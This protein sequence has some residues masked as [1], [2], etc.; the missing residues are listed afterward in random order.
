MSSPD[1]LP[2]VQSLVGSGEGATPQGLRFSLIHV[3]RPG[4]LKAWEYH[5]VEM[6]ET[7]LLFKLLTTHPQIEPAKHGYIFAKPKGYFLP[8][9]RSLEL[10]DIEGV[11][12]LV[13]DVHNTDRLGWDVAYPYSPD[14]LRELLGFSGVM[15]S[16]NTTGPVCDRMRIILPLDRLHTL[17]EFHR[18]TAWVMRLFPLPGVTPLAPHRLVEAPQCTLDEAIAE[19]AWLVEMKGP[20][21]SVAMVPS[22]FREPTFLKPKGPT[23]HHSAVLTALLNGKMWR[24]AMKNAKSLSPQLRHGIATNL[25]AIL[26][27]DSDALEACVAAYTLL[28]PDGVGAAEKLLAA[29]AKE[30]PMTW[31]DLS[32]FELLPY[33]HELTPVAD[34]QAEAA[35]GDAN[36]HKYLFNGS[37]NRYEILQADGSY[38]EDILPEALATMLAP[39]IGDRKAIE[40][41]MKTQ[42]PNYK[43]RA[44]V[45]ESTE[46][47]VEHNGLMTF[48]S[49]VPTR[50][51]PREGDWPDIRAL[52]MN[53]VGEDRREEAFEFFLD[54]LALVVQSIYVQNAPQKMLT[55]VVLHGEQGSG[56]GT[57]V[58]VLEMLYP[59]DSVITV[60]QERL[61]ERFSSWNADTLL[62]VAN[63][64]NSGT[65]KE[66]TL[67]NK[68]K[69]LI[70]DPTVVVEEKGEKAQPNAKNKMTLLFCSNDERPVRI[71]RGD[72]RFIV[73][74]SRT[75]LPQPLIK[76][77]RADMGGPRRQVASFFHH[78]LHRQV[79]ID[80]NTQF[81]TTAWR[82]MQNASLSAVEKAVDEMRVVGYRSMA[83]A[84]ENADDKRLGEARVATAVG[85]SDGC[86]HI[87]SR[88]LICVI[89]HWAHS[90]GLSV[91][92]TIDSSL[93]N[94]LKAAFRDATPARAS[95]KGRGQERVW[96]GLPLDVDTDGKVTRRS[97]E[98][99][100]NVVSISEVKPG[101]APL[102]T[103]EDFTN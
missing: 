95:L 48:N 23:A 79:Q 56:K 90:H 96:L 9:G 27:E 31:A 83:A 40:R 46:R 54:W 21:L 78:L 86:E 6:D 38:L 89:K 55:A 8:R 19:S 18:L 57:L 50:I 52:V 39:T 101:E 22:G 100:L 26:N 69:R 3:T 68:L 32:R 12:A 73:F 60:D 15:H 4:A 43:K 29:A 74:H 62:L 97:G 76:A 36:P 44:P 75:K 53:L 91:P 61:E 72:R 66:K 10:R 34:A 45:Y 70:T 88:E 77:L 17:Q 59:A 67:A 65:T 64:V 103:A 25:A 93:R 1:T 92:D 13:L 94:A 37:A 49:F 30:E 7:H 71:E 5:V 87:P 99:A 28:F 24:W 58:E 35:K 102:G 47:L 20:K 33:G 11:C 16:T 98:K 14:H 81:E 85:S 42:I 84:W 2:A 63:E 82:L 51:V 80:V 41:F